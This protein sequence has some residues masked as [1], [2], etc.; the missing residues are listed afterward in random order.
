MEGPFTQYCAAVC[1]RVRSRPDRA[2]IRSE[3]MGHLEDHAA[4]LEAAG[5]SQEEARAR[6]VE[7]M[8]DPE[9]LG[10]ALDKVHSPWPW[11][12]TLLCTR[13]CQIALALAAVL[14][15]Q[16]LMTEDLPSPR[17][18]PADTADTSAQSLLWENVLEEVRSSGTVTG[19][20]RLG[21]YTLH[22][23]GEA[24]LAYRPD[25]TYD[26]GTVRPGGLRL[27]F[28]VES[29]HLQPWLDDVSI[30]WYALSAAD[31]QGNTYGPE[32][33]G[34]STQSTGGRMVG[35]Q[36][37]SLYDADPAAHRFTVTVAAAGERVTF[38]VAL[39]EGGEKE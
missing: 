20:G 35:H 22:P 32:S 11:R 38:T 2:A 33:L 34:V 3:L 12:L 10:R 21:D 16:N 36:A 15:L 23:H 30:P 1:S 28:L 5:L 8:G 17:F 7:A 18:L 9:A 25:H 29:T 26:N 13:C 19:G 31:D 37:F 27:T 39:K 24:L 6:S 14:A 4:A